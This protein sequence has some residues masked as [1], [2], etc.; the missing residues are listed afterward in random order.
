M[1]NS[2]SFNILFLLLLL[3]NLTIHGQAIRENNY[4]L[5]VSDSDS[6]TC[7]YAD[8]NGN[9]VIPL[10][11]YSICFTDTFRTYA[12]VTL[13]EIGFGAID[14]E[15][16]VLYKIFPYDNG[17]DYIS[18]GLFRILENSKIGFAESTTGKVVIKPQFDCARPFENGVAMVSNNCKTVSEGEHSSWSGD[19]WYYVDKTGKRVDEPMPEIKPAL[20]SILTDP[21]LKLIKARALSDLMELI[22]S[23]DPESPANKLIASQLESWSEEKLNQ[24]WVIFRKSIED[25]I[26]QTQLSGFDFGI[27]M[28]SFK[29]FQEMDKEKIVEDYDIRVQSIGGDQ[30][31]SEFWQDG[32]AVYSEKNAGNIKDEERKVV[33][34]KRYAI[35]RKSIEDG[36]QERYTKMMALLYTLGKDGSITFHD[37]LQP[38]MDFIK[39]NRK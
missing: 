25:Y 5:K 37:P 24:F 17:P 18:D 35:V 10:G 4:L 33:A 29:D 23:S 38:M 32:L 19:N 20:D 3:G 34:K 27:F 6:G 36:T 7:G 14:R 1:K 21:V 39:S 28:L 8:L 2:N 16:N 26:V 30:Y 11:K 9:M 22:K 12:I 15:E 13:P 31:I